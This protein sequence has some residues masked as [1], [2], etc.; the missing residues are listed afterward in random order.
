[1]ANSQE[2]S[3]VVGLMFTVIGAFCSGFAGVYFEK[4]MKQP[5]KTTAS[6]GGPSEVTKKPSMWVRNLQLAAFSMAIGM[7][8]IMMQ[9]MVSSGSSSGIR[10]SDGSG[11][12]N[13]NE[14]IFHSGATEETGHYFLKG[15]SWMVWIMVLN[16]AL[17]GLCVAFVIK[18]ADNILKGF[19]C[20]VATII[21]AVAAVPLF[22]FSLGPAFLIGMLVIL[23]SVLLYGGNIKV[24]GDYWNQ[25]PPMCS[26]FRGETGE[27]NIELASQRNKV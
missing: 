3:I 9:F 15:F 10:S 8:N 2:Q 27:P 26:K 13:G 17:G 14:A 6:L 21:A 19:A 25:E 7:F 23:I 18:Y 24:T 4:M 20:A 22:G 12:D 11:S 16:N 5:T 1:M